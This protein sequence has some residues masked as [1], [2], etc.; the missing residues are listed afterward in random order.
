MDRLVA[1]AEG[2][3]KGMI[4]SGYYTRA[5]LQDLVNLRWRNVDLAQ[6]TISFEQSKTGAVVVI[7]INSNLQDHLLTLPASDSPA[8]YVF[9]TLAGKSGSGRSGLSMEFKRI[10]AA[11]KIDAG[12]ARKRRGAKGR[13]LSALSFHSLRHTFNSALAN[14]DVPLEIRQKLTGHATAAMNAH[15]T[16]HE[17]DTIRRAIESIPPIGRGANERNS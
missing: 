3:W 1:T 14:G 6:G 5:R 7:A 11:A 2:D 4:L 9:P 12:C 15:Y 17:L 13:N 16:H 8:A 10:M